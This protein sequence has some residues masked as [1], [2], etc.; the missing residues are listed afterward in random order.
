[1]YNVNSIL[2]YGDFDLDFQYPYPDTT[3]QKT[4]FSPLE[5]PELDPS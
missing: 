4:G 2:I 3:P 5:K 1:M